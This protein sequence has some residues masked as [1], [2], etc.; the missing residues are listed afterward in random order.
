[1]VVETSGFHRG[2]KIE[3]DGEVWEIIEYQ[4]QKMAQRSP[5]VTVKARNIV[6]GAVQEKKFRSGDKFETPDIKK[7]TMQFLYSDGNI[8]H[9]MDTETYD[10]QELSAAQVGSAADFMSEHQEIQVNFING[11]PY[12]IEFLKHIVELKVTEAD[13]GVKGDTATSATKPATLETGAK[14]QVPLF[15]NPG[16][17]IKVDT[18]DGSYIERVR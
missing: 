5:V 17:M 10:Q 13:P 9:F 4:Q 18:R 1:M 16:D 15:V 2:L 8:Y 14:V 11:N 7:R 6:T 3:L 12:G